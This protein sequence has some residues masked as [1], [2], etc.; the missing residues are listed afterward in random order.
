MSTL[1]RASNAYRSNAVQTSGEKLVVMLYDGWLSAL[2]ISK[3][4]I[5]SQN[6]VVAHEYLVRA[7]NIVSELNNTLDMS[8]EVSQQLRPLYEFFGRQLVEANVKKDISVIDVQYPLVKGLRDSWE[9]AMKT[10]SGP[11][12]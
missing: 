3:D 6:L 8:Y 5:S 2:E 12:V 4:A 7:Q 11:A 10:I 9:Q 1:N